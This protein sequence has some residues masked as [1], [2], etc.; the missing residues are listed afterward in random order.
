[1]T[2]LFSAYLLGVSAGTLVLF[3]LPAY[4]ARKV[5]THFNANNFFRKIPGVLLIL[6]RIYSFSEYMLG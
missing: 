1:M 3:M 4:L 6:L 2:F 5:V